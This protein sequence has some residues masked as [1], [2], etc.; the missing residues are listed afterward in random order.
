MLLLIQQL[1]TAWGAPGA[2]RT[3]FIPEDRLRSSPL[4]QLQTKRCYHLYH[5]ASNPCAAAIAADL[6][7]QFVSPN[8]SGLRTTAEP[9]HLRHDACSAFLLY[10]NAET[11][12]PGARADT[13]V[14]ELEAALEAG[15]GL[16]LAHE[17]RDG[18][19]RLTFD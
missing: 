4:P 6:E 9:E 8:H 18:W 7:A 19:R 11:F 12:A 16:L 14:S 5:S 3:I 15:T 17:R 10:L 2:D 13:L 1:V